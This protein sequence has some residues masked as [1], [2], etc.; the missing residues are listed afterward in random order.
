MPPTPAALLRTRFSAYSKGLGDYVVKTTHPDNELLRD[1]SRA[2]SGAVVSTLA[3]DVAASAK[4]ARYSDLEILAESA[5]VAPD[6]AVVAFCY[7][8]AIVGQA[9]FGGRS[10]ARER[11]TE[12][13]VFMRDGP[14]APWLFHSST[15]KSE[16]LKV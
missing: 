1:G 12:S 11:V 4:M 13:S 14:D 15:T 2:A 9:G 3:A 7:V 5:G 10:S 16:K 6:Q 8:V